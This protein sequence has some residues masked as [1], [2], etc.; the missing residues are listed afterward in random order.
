MT[1]FTEQWFRS[2]GFSEQ[3]VFHEADGTETLFRVYGGA[4]SKIVGSC[5][6]MSNPVTVSAAEFDA[7]IVKWG[8]LCLYVA[9]FKVSKGTPMYIGRIDQSYSRK[10][11]D[12]GT[13]VFIGGNTN[14]KQVWIDPKKAMTHLILVGKPS[15]LQQDRMVV[16]REGRA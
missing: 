5:Y 3:P 14:A 13:D 12:D 11:I 1:A 15:R 2:K 9:T 7:N 4:T 10:D 8:N 16:A 6:S